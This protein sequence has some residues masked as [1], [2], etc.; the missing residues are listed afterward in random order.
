MGNNRR[1]LNFIPSLADRPI[2][3]DRVFPFRSIFVPYRRI[4]CALALLLAFLMLF[5]VPISSAADEIVPVGSGSVPLGRQNALKIESWQGAK[6]CGESFPVTISGGSTNGGV[7]FTATNCTVSPPHGTTSDVF[8]VKVNNAGAYAL[9]A[10]MSGNDSFS[11]VSDTRSGMAGKANQAPLVITGWGSAKDYYYTFPIN[12]SGGST[13][14]AVSFEADGCYVT[15]ATGAVGDYFNVTVTRVGSYS[16]KAILSGSGNYLPAQSVMQSGVARK[17]KQ[18]AIVIE[19]WEEDASYGESFVVSIFGGS[20]TE[21]LVITPIGCEAAKVGASEYEITPDSASPYSLT[22]SRAGNYGYYDVSASVGGVCKK[23]RQAA[24][25]VQ[26]WA[27]SRNCTDSFQIQVKGGAPGGTVRFS[28]CG[29]TVSPDNGTTDST[30]TVTV[31]QVGA[32]SLCA[33]MDATNCYYEVSGRTMHGTAG[34]ATQ[35]R[36]SAENWVDNAP[37]GSSFDIVVGGGNGT[38]CTSITTNGACTALL[39]TDD[40]N[41]YT[42][43]VFD[44]PAREYSI[45]LEKA[46]DASYAEASAVSYTGR[47]SGAVQREIAVTGWQ[48][49]F[50][51][52]ESFLIRLSDGAG[53]DELN[54]I[55]EGCTVLPAESGEDGVYCVTV[56]AGEGGAYSVRVERAGDASYAF[57]STVRSGS[58]RAPEAQRRAEQA[59]KRQIPMQE[60]TLLCALVALSVLALVFFILL[61]RA[62][63]HG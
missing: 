60:D 46:G 21:P 24:L 34:K 9:T 8:T 15:P 28:A 41:T 61:I 2:L 18:S 48:E 56:T 33:Y 51:T 35:N 3:S 58:A 5:L 42:I 17:S 53:G 36:L 59:E 44:D 38:G 40:G 43:T 52:G 55:A 12:V 6:N 22:A 49:S 4:A 7:T 10:T 27:E 11:A 32:Y 62:R 1:C 23:A 30:F 45:L 54:L 47:T 20:T 26:G 25:S 19:D 37:A 50:V 13:N 14:G 16:L 31:T 57:S 63:K 39:K 29:C